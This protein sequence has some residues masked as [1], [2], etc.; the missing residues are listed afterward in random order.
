MKL[1]Q[2]TDI[3]LKHIVE[4][5]NAIPTKMGDNKP[6][7][8]PEQKRALKEMAYMFNEYG[9]AFQGEQKIMDAAKAIGQFMELAENYAVTKGIDVFQENIIKQN[10]AEAKKKAQ[11]LMKLAQEC[12]VRKQQLGVLFDDIRHV[13]TR[14]Y[15]VGDPSAAPVPPTSAPDQ[16]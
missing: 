4:N 10:F 1:S 16:Q 5:M 7:M 2:K 15:K 11:Q 9:S 14:Y 8:T 6:Q 13:V 3:S 12:Y